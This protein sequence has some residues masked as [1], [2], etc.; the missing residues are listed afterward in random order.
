MR[1]VQV[2]A[3]RYATFVAKLDGRV[4]QEYGLT[5]DPLTH[6]MSCYI[7]AKTNSSIDFN[8]SFKNA[9]FTQ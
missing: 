1:Y 5:L 7:P 2:E 9:A 4:A 3:Q 6:T 8:A